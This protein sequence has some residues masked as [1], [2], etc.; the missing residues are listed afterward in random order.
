MPTLDR[1]KFIKRLA[2]KATNDLKK[3]K[4]KGSSM[5][6]NTKVSD[7]KKSDKEKFID[8]VKE[9]KKEPRRKTSL[10]NVA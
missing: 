10:K 9:K 4:N 8:S 1:T 2:D 6:F 5:F 3:V 7:K